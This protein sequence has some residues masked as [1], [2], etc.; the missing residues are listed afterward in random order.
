MGLF[1][2]T[3]PSLQI[4]RNDPN[5]DTCKTL[6]MNL[7][8]WLFINSNLNNRRA[9]HEFLSFHA[10][11]FPSTV[12]NYCFCDKIYTKKCH[13]WRI[14]VKTSFQIFEVIFAYKI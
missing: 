14:F 10:F 3:E 11:K 4:R 9:W 12:W 13:V 5:D 7:P 8:S 2:F 1:S 6:E